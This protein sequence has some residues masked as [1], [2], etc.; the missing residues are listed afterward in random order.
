[1]KA[2]KK[3]KKNES[4]TLSLLPTLG[5][6]ETLDLGIKFIFTIVAIMLTGLLFI[7]IHDYVTQSTCFS[8]NTVSIHGLNRLTRTETL[9]QAGLTPGDTLLNINALKMKKRLV[10]HPWINTS[11]IKRTWPHTLDIFIQEEVPVARVNL[12]NAPPLLINTQGIPFAENPPETTTVTMKLPLIKGLI[13]EKKEEQWGFHGTLYQK[14]MGLLRE[15][16][17]L[18]ITSITADIATGITVD[19]H[20]LSNDLSGQPVETPITLKLGF[21]QFKSKFETAGK[22]FQHLQQQGMGKNIKAMDLF[23]PE[24]VIVT[25]GRH[26][27]GAQTPQGA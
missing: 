5:F 2:N 7:F 1:M 18:P 17:G 15:D 25:P 13:L 9:V 26:T 20:F 8:I 14:I 11:R 12:E 3:I 24:R 4:S 22:I 21:S 6:M 27:S 19:T 23:N 10:A 16:P